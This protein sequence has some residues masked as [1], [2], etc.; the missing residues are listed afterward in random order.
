[1]TISGGRCV[2]LPWRPSPGRTPGRE[3]GWV[4]VAQGDVVDLAEYLHDLLLAALLAGSQPLRSLQVLQPAQALRLADH[5]PP[6]FR[7]WRAFSPWGA[8]PSIDRGTYSS[9]SNRTSVSV[10]ALLLR[11]LSAR[12]LASP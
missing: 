1:M 3:N 6:S 12:C 11:R 9:I 7:Y 5:Y 8:C 10:P 2:L 4:L